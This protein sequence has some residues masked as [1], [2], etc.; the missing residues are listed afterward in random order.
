MEEKKDKLSGKFDESKGG[1]K[2]QVGEF[3]GDEQLQG[4]GKADQAGGKLEQGVA[5]AKEKVG[6][7]IDKLTG[8]DKK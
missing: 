5:G 2:E 4:E 8:D 3:T 7:A 1:L 6:D